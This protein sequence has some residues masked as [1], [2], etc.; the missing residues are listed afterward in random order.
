MLVLNEL[1]VGGA[2]RD[3]TTQ[4][5]AHGNNQYYYLSSL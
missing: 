1:G 2:L 4:A 3:R 5:S